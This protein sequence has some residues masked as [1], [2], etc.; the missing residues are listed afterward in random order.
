M[1]DCS[2]VCL[3]VGIK[4]LTCH[5]IYSFVDERMLVFH[6]TDDNCIV[7]KQIRT[8]SKTSSHVLKT[9]LKDSLLTTTDGRRSSRIWFRNIVIDVHNS[10]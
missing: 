10:C 6:K 8:S 4:I 7:R 2:D 5:S 1:Q 9:R 3:F